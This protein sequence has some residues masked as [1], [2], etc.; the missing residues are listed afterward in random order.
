MHG[1]ADLQGVSEILFID[2][3]ICATLQISS[4]FINRES[5]IR[6]LLQPYPLLPMGR[7][8]PVPPPLDLFTRWSPLTL[9]WCDLFNCCLGISLV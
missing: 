7:A 9:F 4:S 1:P 5:S 3:L 8:L 6:E 2:E